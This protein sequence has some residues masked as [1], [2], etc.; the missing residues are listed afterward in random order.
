MYFGNPNTAATEFVDDD[1]ANDPGI[2]PPQ[3]VKVKMFVSK[4]HSARYDRTLTR[5]W[6]TIKT[7][8]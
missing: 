1:V 2:Y 6:T 5:T 4:P 7:G 3:D 8:K